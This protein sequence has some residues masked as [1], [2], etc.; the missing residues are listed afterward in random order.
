[1]TGLGCAVCSRRIGE[2]DRHWII[3]AD[4]RVICYACGSGGT[5]RNCTAV[6][7]HLLVFPGC[8]VG[9]HDIHDHPM[10][11]GHG[12]EDT[13]RWLASRP[14]RAQFTGTLGIMADQAGAR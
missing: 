12:A 1:M 13:R 8:G 6:L 14:R 3:A 11:L 5:V 7:N 10:I 4:L 2:R 9:W